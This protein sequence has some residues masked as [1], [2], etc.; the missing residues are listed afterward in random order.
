MQ[1]LQSPPMHFAMSFLD[2]RFGCRPLSVA[3]LFCACPVGAQAP[4][5]QDVHVS[6]GAAI[7]TAPLYPGSRD[8]RTRIFPV[9]DARHGRWYVG[10]V[11]ASPNVLGIGVDVARDEGLRLGA[12]LTGD[13]RSLRREEDADRLAGLGDVERTQRANVY[14]A[15]SAPRYEL[16]GNV[17]R[18]IRGRDLGTVVQLEA[19]LRFRPWASWMLSVGP[20]IAWVDDD[21][22]Q[23]VFGVDEA[24]SAASG[25]RRFD[26]RGG[27]MLLR[28]NA[29]IVRRIDEHWSL[30]A[31][32]SVARLRGDASDSPITERESQPSLMFFGSYRF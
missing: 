28:M 27:L 6:V 5:S 25:L 19:D 16:R 26:A 7:A 24:Q 3:L 32:G 4:A 2:L 13:I 31:R 23:T 17:A 10:P 8:S 29:S 30:G 20:S 22:A 14:T 11:P 9:I 12:A 1:F 15:W 21:Y 18:D